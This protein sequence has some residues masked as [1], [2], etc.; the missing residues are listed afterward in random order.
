[1]GIYMKWKTEIFRIRHAIREI[2]SAA[3]D[4]SWK[5]QIT[6]EPIS[7]KLSAVVQAKQRRSRQQLINCRC[8]SSP[9]FRGH[10]T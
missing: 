9:V 3:L 6:P 10:S 8:N 2:A 1:M 7:E 5:A 4:N